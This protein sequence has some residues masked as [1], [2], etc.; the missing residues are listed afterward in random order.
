MNQGKK[1]LYKGSQLRLVSI[2]AVTLIRMVKLALMHG[3]TLKL[4]I[5]LT[6]IAKELKFHALESILKILSL[7]LPTSIVCLL[8]NL[9]LALITLFTHMVHLGWKN[10]KK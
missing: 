1:I 6:K 8:T 3:Q 5:C 2:V 10:I 4:T 7:L 9:N